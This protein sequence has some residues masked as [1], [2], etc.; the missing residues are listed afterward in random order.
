MA[1]TYQELLEAGVHFGHLSMKWDPQMAPYIFMEKNGIHIIDLMKT[2]RMLE[3]ACKVVKNIAKSGKKILF[4]GTKKQAQEIIRSNAQRVNMPYVTDRWLGGM[5]TNFST[6]RKSV[7]KM[8]SLSKFENEGSY[9]TLSKKEKLMVSRDL[10]KLRRVL[11]GISDMT[12]VPA[13]IFI[14]D[15][16]KEHIAVA[17]ATKLNIPT[18]GIVDTNSNPNMIDFPIPGNDDAAKAID[19][20][21]TAFANAIAEGLAERKQE[22]EAEA[23]RKEE[24]MN[25]EA[26]A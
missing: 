21:T 26:K 23:K 1:V 22:K 18:F 9:N 25:A 16:K 5:L 24:S 7:K 20:I 10:G 13:A 14:V 4:V 12:Q 19:I 8:E 17:E 11:D 15:I 3:E 6:I 2:Q